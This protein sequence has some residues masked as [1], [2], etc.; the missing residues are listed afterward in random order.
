MNTGDAFRATHYEIVTDPV[1]YDP[2]YVPELIRLKNKA[3]ISVPKS[4]A[5]SC[6]SFELES[7]LRKGESIFNTN[8]TD[9]PA[10]EIYIGY[11]PVVKK[12]NTLKASGRTVR[13]KRSK[14]RKRSLTIKRKKAITVKTPKGPVRYTLLS[15]KKAKFRKYFKV[16]VK[17]GR[18][19]VKKGL[20]K[21]KYRLR[22]RVRAA[23]NSLFKAKTKNV[24]VTVRVR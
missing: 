11:K 20:K 10:K 13:L 2:K 21:G 15:V 19:T 22:V 8:K 5:V 23:G 3:K 1:A 12:A 16:N 9:A 24:T 7:K 6:C 17:N 18:I 14:L 4:G